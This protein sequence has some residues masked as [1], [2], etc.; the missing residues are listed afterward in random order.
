MFDHAGKP[1]QVWL[2]EMQS[3]EFLRASITRGERTAE[4]W[5]VLRANRTRVY[6]ARAALGPQSNA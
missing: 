3:T 2:A 6:A 4:C 5:A 1:V